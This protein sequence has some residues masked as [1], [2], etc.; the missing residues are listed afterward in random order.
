MTR[1]LAGCL[2]LLLCVGCG[3]EADEVGSGA[4]GPGEELTLSDCGRLL[5][6][7]V[8]DTL[9]WAGGTPSIELDRCT[10][11]TDQGTVRV[12]RVLVPSTPQESLEERC[13]ELEAEEVD[14]LTDAVA[15]CAVVGEDELSVSALVAQLDDDLVVEARVEPLEG[16]EPD[17]IQAALV[18]TV[19]AFSS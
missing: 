17:R 16:T 11:T 8:L 3:E 6:S 13:A 1:L 2:L 18:E 10:L 14:W 15:Q 7:S 19:E 9:G 4:A 12:S 5:P